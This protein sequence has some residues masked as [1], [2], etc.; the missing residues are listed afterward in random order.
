LEGGIEF[1]DECVAHDMY[2]KPRP[3]KNKNAHHHH[4]HH[5]RMKTEKKRSKEARS[6]VSSPFS[7]QVPPSFDENISQ[8]QKKSGFESKKSDSS[9]SSPVYIY[10]KVARAPFNASVKSKID[11]VYITDR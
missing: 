4:H 2:I 3:E 5:L 6:L 7:A 1:E 9:S 10:I 8:S 11:P